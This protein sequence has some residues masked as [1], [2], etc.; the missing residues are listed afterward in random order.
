MIATYI[1]KA[2]QSVL[3]NMKCDD[4]KAALANYRE[5]LKAV[6]SKEH[7]RELEESGFNCIYRDEA[8]MIE[9]TFK[10]VC[11]MFLLES[12]NGKRSK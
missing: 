1:R 4:P 6:N 9:D 5:C 8:R 10:L 11:D 2:V 3:L 7:Y 12:R